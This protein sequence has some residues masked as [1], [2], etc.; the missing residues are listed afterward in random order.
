MMACLRATLQAR[1]KG[2]AA[3]LLVPALGAGL[4]L[5]NPAAGHPSI[6]SRSVGVPH[7]LVSAIHRLLGPGRI[8][9]GSTPTWKSTTKPAAVLTNS[10]GSGGD[11]LGY[12]VSLSQDGTTAL[13][14]A[15]TANSNKGAAYIFH[16]KSA[17]SWKT[18]STPAAMLTDSSGSNGDSFGDAVSLSADGTT[19]LIAAFGVSSGQGA[20]YVFHVT[21]ESAWTTTSSPQ[22]VLTVP[23]TNPP[24]DLGSAVALSATG[25]TALVGATSVNSGRGATYVFHVASPGSW[26][27][28]SH[29]TAVLTTAHT[30]DL[31]TGYAVALSSD[32][33][34]AVVG[35][36]T[37]SKATVYVFHVA[38]AGKW[39][40]TSTPTAALGNKSGTAEDFFGLAVAI[41]A[42]G[43]TAVV[44]AQGQKTNVGAAYVFHVKSEGA[45][46]TTSVPTADLT[47]GPAAQSDNVGCAVA[48]SSNGSTALLGAL[49]VNGQDG[50]AYVFHV[51][52]AASWKTTSKPTASL[53]DSSSQNGDQ[54]GLAAAL[55]G[56]GLTALLGAPHVNASAGQAYIYR[57]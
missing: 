53:S 21:S 27:S 20:A 51:T 35:S 16:V 40:T 13:V 2:G 12:A 36:S 26:K 4:A 10:A 5:P 50:A 54:F 30:K 47:N 44:G 41:S 43:L 7:G 11:Q 23:Q 24:A 14:G 17:G 29:P 34:T 25:T 46:K 6:P 57:A 45:W 56:D 19:A 33:T 42:D 9:L 31:Q 28:T 39:K 38:S 22:A 37:D 3:A 52:S 32:G 8:G 49:G 18:T 55:S 1:L 48:V 15:F